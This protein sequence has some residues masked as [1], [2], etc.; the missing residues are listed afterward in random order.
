MSHTSATAVLI[1]AVVLGLAVPSSAQTATPS[2]KD[3]RSASHQ[4]ERVCVTDRTGT[5]TKGRVVRISATSIALSVNDQAREWPASEVTWI[6]QRRGSAGRGALIGLAAGAVIGPVLVALD[7][8]ADDYVL[9][10]APFSAG[11]GAS[12][13]AAIGAAWR[14]ERVLYAAGHRSTTVLVAPRLAPG[15]VELRAQIGF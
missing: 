15:V 6:T 7:N 4:G 5:T 3:L 1:T 11:L 10:F 2:F 8:G 13:G 14:P 12:I 9:F